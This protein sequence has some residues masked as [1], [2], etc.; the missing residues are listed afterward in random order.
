[1]NKDLDQLP[2]I[3]LALFFGQA[4]WLPVY[5]RKMPGNISDVKTIQNMLADIDFLQLDKVK[6][7][8]E[9]GEDLS[10]A[11]KEKTE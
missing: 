3:N 7:I 2:Q 4:S 6:L 8:M 10:D 9:R 5:F 11:R 1:M